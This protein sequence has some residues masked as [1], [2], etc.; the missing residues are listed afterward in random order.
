MSPQIVI[1]SVRQW[2]GG[3]NSVLFDK[4]VFSA[5]ANVNIIENFL[6]DAFPLENIVQRD[7]IISERSSTVDLESGTE[8]SDIQNQNGTYLESKSEESFKDK[9]NES[10]SAPETESE[11]PLIF[12]NT[13]EEVTNDEDVVGVLPVIAINTKKPLLERA[14]VS[15]IGIQLQMSL[16]EDSDENLAPVLKLSDSDSDRLDSDNSTP[17]LLSVL[18]GDS[19]PKQSSSSAVGSSTPPSQTSSLA[20][21][22][23][24]SKTTPTRG[25]VVVLGS[26]TPSPSNSP[27]PSSKNSPLILNPDRLESDV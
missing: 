4:V 17:L 13:E 14:S 12:Q 22:T 23:P 18:T 8:S 21:A 9:L 15:D 11:K 20:F 7:S 24:L 19:S 27:K 3:N 2:L 5:K 26:R 25:L 10:E 6:G 16:D 1:E